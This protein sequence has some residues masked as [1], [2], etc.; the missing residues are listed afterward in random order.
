MSGNKRN[1]IKQWN[2]YLSQLLENNE[3]CRDFSFA[4]K[5]F[6]STHFLHR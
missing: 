3:T 6:M 5:Y 4:I 2:T 1:A